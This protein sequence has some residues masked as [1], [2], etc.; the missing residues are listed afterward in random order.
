MEVQ[1]ISLLP[2]WIAPV[3]SPGKKR[4][5]PPVIGIETNY[6]QNKKQIVSK[7]ETNCF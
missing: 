6:F 7:I 5:P 1:D 2:H 3:S 4:V